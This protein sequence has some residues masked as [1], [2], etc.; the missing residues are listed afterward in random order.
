[1]SK[2]CIEFGVHR[3]T[4]QKGL[5]ARGI[6]YGRGTKFTTLE[7]VS[8]LYSDLDHERTLETREKRIALER[9]NAEKAG[10]LVSM[11]EVTRLYTEAMLPWRQRLLALPGECAARCN[12]SD[13]QFA[14]EALQ[15][16]V[17]E[18]LPLIREQLPKG[19]Q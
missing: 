6:Q 7:I 16:W 8:A 19:K 5:L 3:E 15:R 14:R 12:P 18:S 9:E 2:A 11:E 10:E 4:L 13:A 17:D 1:M